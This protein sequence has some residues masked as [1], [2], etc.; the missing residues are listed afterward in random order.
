MLKNVGANLFLER[1]KICLGMLCPSSISDCL[2]AEF[3]ER[4]KYYFTH[5]R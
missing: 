1:L 5:S 4:H 2:V 3:T